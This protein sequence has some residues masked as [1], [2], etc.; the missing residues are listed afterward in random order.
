ME[1]RAFGMCALCMTLG[2]PSMQ[3]ATAIIAASGE[4]PSS[5]TPSAVS[6]R[7]MVIS[8]VSGC[9]FCKQCIIENLLQQRQQIKKKKKEYQL[10]KEKERARRTEEMQQK[11][12]E[13]QYKMKRRLLLPNSGADPSESSSQHNELSA[14]AHSDSARTPT[15]TVG[16]ILG[17]TGGGIVGLRASMNVGKLA[18]S[19][20]STTALDEKKVPKPRKYT[21]DPMSKNQEKM[22]LSDLVNVTLT[23]EPL[24]SKEGSAEDA[25]AN[26]ATLPDAR[27]RYMC[28]VCNITFMSS[29]EV[30]TLKPSG[31]CI[32]AN[33]FNSFVRHT[34]KCPV[35]EKKLAKEMGDVIKVN[36][37]TRKMSS[38]EGK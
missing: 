38:G 13:V 32:C 34:W 19:A 33:C 22:S 17:G 5:H 16:G 7:P 18:Q 14:L 6:H 21:V 30:Y 29:S 27:R 1:R 4:I 25:S 12:M 23:P 36:M 24:T 2:M 9:L 15:A 37:E 26:L 20:A 35:T 8:P 11:Q 31:Q 28:P 10:Y 3:K